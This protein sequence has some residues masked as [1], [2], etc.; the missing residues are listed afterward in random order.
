[1][2]ARNLLMTI[3]LLALALGATACSGK[4]TDEPAVAATPEQAI[5]RIANGLADAS[6]QVIWQALPASYQQDVENLLHEAAGEMDRELWGKTFSVLGKLSRVLSEKRDFILDH[7][8]V[9]S[10]VENRSE[11]ESNWGAVAGMFDVL[12]SSELADLDKLRT[13]DVGE[14]L[15]GTGARFMKQIVR[16]SSLTPDDPFGKQL[17]NL[18]NVKVTVVSSEGDSARVRTEVPDMPAKEEDYVRVEGKWITRSLADA[19]DSRMAEVRKQVAEYSGEKTAENKQAAM[20]QLGMV[21]SA[22]DTLLAADTAEDFN[23]AAG[24]MMGMAMGAIMAQSA[25]ADRGMASSSPPGQAAPPEDTMTEPAESAAVEAGEGLQLPLSP[26]ESEEIAKRMRA[27]DRLSIEVGEAQ[28]FLGQRMRVIGK[29][30]LDFTGKLTA[31]DARTLTFEREFSGG[32]MGFEMDAAE[33][34][35]LRPLR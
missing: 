16:A 27:A 20:M 14:F 2:K 24:A 17:A 18:R 4:T 10:Q 12:V 1:M 22:L 31:A 6:P 30:G 33:I 11:A 9:A 23:A 28:D 5:T 21:E 19:W 8:M 34:E 26:E 3:T 7:P 15:A 25:N 13:L 32:T 35:S 29:D